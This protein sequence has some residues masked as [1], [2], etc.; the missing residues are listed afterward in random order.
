M[1]GQSD[2]SQ[3]P[4]T[5]LLQGNGD[6]EL[7]SGP[8]AE[9]TIIFNGAKIEGNA[10]ALVN[11]STMQDRIHRTNTLGLQSDSPGLKR[12][13]QDQQDTARAEVADQTAKLGCLPSTGFMVIHALWA[14]HIRVWVNGIGFDPTLMRPITVPPRKPMPQMF[15]NWLG[16]RRL[17]LSR[18]LSDPPGDWTWS[19]TNGQIDVRDE[20]PCNPPFVAFTDVLEALIDA[21]K[22]GSLLRLSQ[23]AHYEVE[24]SESLLDDHAV[25]RQLEGCFHLLRDQSETANWW[26][27]DH[28]GSAVINRLAKLLRSAQHQ[29]FLL[30][31]QRAGMAG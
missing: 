31:H 1:D 18:W 17:S 20:P 2:S 8:T 22:S 12:W 25:T 10:S 21:Q 9:V 16:E 14:Q 13:L 26:L 23:L 7:H 29:A 28:Q 11:A 15:H 27:F 3:Y 24:P 19:L 5:V 6:L 4:L 30:M